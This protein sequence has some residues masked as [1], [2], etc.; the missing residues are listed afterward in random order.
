MRAV[1]GSEPTEPTSDTQQAPS[2]PHPATPAEA[3]E[4]ARAANE[5]IRTLNHATRHSNDCP[6][7]RY[8]ADAYLLIAELGQ[9]ASR[10]PQ[11]L[12]QISAFLQR[13][14]QHGLVS[15]EGGEHVGD[16][17]GAIGTA[18]NQLEGPATRAAQTLATSLDIGREAIAFAS[19]DGPE[20]P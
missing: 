14:L 9:L 15:V 20:P 12:A 19:Y 8:P 3:L 2:Q 6:A 1:N 10:L 11:L 17:L 16:P 5:A 4:F 18:S 13:Q 7:L